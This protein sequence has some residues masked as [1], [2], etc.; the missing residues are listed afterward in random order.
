MVR[1]RALPVL[2]LALAACAPAR[3]RP[4][5]SPLLGQ[6]VEVTAHDLDGREVRV[7]GA[8]GIRVLDF[9]A[10]WCEPC[11]EQM[12]L[13]ERLSRERAGDG[14][15]VVAISF[16]DQ[17]PA[18]DAFLAEVPVTFPVLWDRNGDALGDRL[19]IER[20]PTTLVLDRAGIVRQVHVG[21]DRA[22][23]EKLERELSRLL[24]EP[25][26]APGPR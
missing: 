21:F 9:W 24:A 20:L 14:L 23:G 3:P 26:P 7:G 1:Q 19:A 10:S 17:R 2:L 6:R 22:E 11:R 16:D 12:P 18:L 5:P 8:G 15:A 13:L 4:S 25:P